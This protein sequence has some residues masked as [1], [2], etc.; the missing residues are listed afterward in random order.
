VA[1]EAQK[2]YE[3][4][5]VKASEEIIETWIN[6]HYVSLNQYMFSAKLFLETN[7]FKF[8]VIASARVPKTIESWILFNHWK[9][10][11]II[12]ISKI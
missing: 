6:S 8:S 12:I 10:N 5:L 1:L 11:R 2:T 4:A 7:H 3:N 9:P